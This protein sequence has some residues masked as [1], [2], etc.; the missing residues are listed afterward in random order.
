MFATC[1][2]E[3]GVD[4]LN[5]RLVLQSP[6][7]CGEPFNMEYTGV[8][9][10]GVAVSAIRWRAC[11]AFGYHYGYPHRTRHPLSFAERPP[12]QL[13]YFDH[14]S[15]INARI[16]SLPIANRAARFNRRCRIC[17]IA[18]LYPQEGSQWPPGTTSK[19]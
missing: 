16:L 15:P 10:F 12:R 6:A 14:A 18:V 13:E 3:C 2:L 4:A 1:S 9:T 5:R 11:S 19:V 7:P 17:T 8:N